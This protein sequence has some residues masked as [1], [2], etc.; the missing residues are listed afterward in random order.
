MPVV[1]MKATSKTAHDKTDSLFIY[2]FDSPAQGE[3]TIV[4]NLTNVYDVGD[5]AAIA[6]PGTFLPGVEIKPRKVFGVASS[7]MALGKVDAALDTDLTA[8]FDADQA[9]RPFKVTLTVEVEGRYA[10]D[11][12]KA[13]RKALKSGAGDLVDAVPL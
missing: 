12:E 11:A 13:A 4:A 8:Q 3:K 9:P 6:L 5:V 2:T 1:A 7:G 10:E